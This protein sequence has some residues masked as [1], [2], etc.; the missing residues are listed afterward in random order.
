MGGT[1]RAIGCVLAFLAGCGGD[2]TAAP[3]RATTDGGADDAQPAQGT[4]DGASGAPGASVFPGCRRAASLDDAGAGVIACSV[5][6][7]LVQ[8]VNDAGSDWQ[9][10]SDDPQ[11]CG[12]DTPNAGG[13]AE[14]WACQ[15]LCGA[16][17]YAVSCGG[18]RQPPLL[19]AD[20][21][22]VEQPPFKTQDPPPRCR[23]VGAALT[24]YDSLCCPC[25]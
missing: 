1:T 5:G 17:E 10:A 18:S 11:G 3:G 19:G 21:G 25:E 9:C 12:A 4:G 2:V 23:R 7:M 13:S 6:R 24:E 15:N 8:C 16:G 20:G 22:F 14:G